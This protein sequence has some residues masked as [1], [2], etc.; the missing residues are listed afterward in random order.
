MASEG[1]EEFAAFGVPQT[2][3]LVPE[4]AEARV[5][6]SGLKLTP[7]IIIHMASEGIEEFAAFGVPQTDGL[8]M[9]KRKRGY[10]HRD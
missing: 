9:R 6:P 4:E 2:D 8:V 3:G 7:L 10:C 1:I 5:L